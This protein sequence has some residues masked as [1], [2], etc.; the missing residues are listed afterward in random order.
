MGKNVYGVGDKVAVTKQVGI[1]LPELYG[2]VLTIS[3]IEPVGSIMVEEQE[4]F[5]RETP[6][7]FIPAHLKPVDSFDIMRYRKYGS[8]YKS[9]DG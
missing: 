1:A 2:K 3:G 9:E 7:A 4:F 8:I 6:R 5:E